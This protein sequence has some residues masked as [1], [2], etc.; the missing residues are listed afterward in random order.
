MSLTATAIRG[1]IGQSGNFLGQVL[2]EQQVR[3]K[4]DLFFHEYFIFSGS[5]AWFHQL[6]GMEEQKEK[7]RIEMKGTV[8]CPVFSGNEAEYKN[9]RVIASNWMMIEGQERKYPALEMRSAMRGKAL[10]VVVGL[11]QGKL[12]ERNWCRN[13]LKRIGEILPK[14]EQSL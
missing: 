9:W 2:Q 8:R 5:R 6:E 10:D 14:R 3:R 13:V 12:M 7:E 1:Q 4:K 11:E